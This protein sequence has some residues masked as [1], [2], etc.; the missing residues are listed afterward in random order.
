MWQETPRSNSEV[1]IFR[2]MGL[3]TG[4]RAQ[5]RGLEGRTSPAVPG[6]T[7]SGPTSCSGACSQ[8]YRAEV[9]PASPTMTRTVDTAIQ[10]PASRTL[11]N[12]ITT[13][14]IHQVLHPTIPLSLPAPALSHF[15]I[16]LWNFS[17]LSTVSGDTCQA[18][19]ECCQDLRSHPGAESMGPKP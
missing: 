5:R 10:A 14:P 2:G 19:L 11:T 15:S 12:P 13:T 18:S 1:D 4:M 8:T 16:A 7:W 6:L 3:Q 9:L 17:F